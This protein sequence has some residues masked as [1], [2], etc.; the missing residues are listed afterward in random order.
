MVHRLAERL[1][2]AATAHI[3]AVYGIPPFERELGH[4]ADITRVARPLQPV[5]HQDVPNGF[6]LRKLLVNQHLSLRFGPVQPLGHRKPSGVQAAN[7]E[8]PQYREQMRVLNERRKRQQIL[9]YGMLR[10]P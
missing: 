4:A 6:V 1:G 10:A 8:I 9:F 3:C 5:N 7:R 2:S